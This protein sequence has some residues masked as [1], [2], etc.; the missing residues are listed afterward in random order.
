[1]SDQQV[2]DG[3][4][5]DV[6]IVR[7]SETMRRG[8][9]ELPWQPQGMVRWFSP[10]ELA[11][12]GMRAALSA[13]F[14]EYAD[15]REL[16]AALHDD[17][18]GAAEPY[19][20]SRRTDTEDG[21][22]IDY[23]AD[24]GDGF[25]ST[26]TVAWLLAQPTLP[27]SGGDATPVPRERSAAPRAEELKAGTR[28][29][30]GHVLVMGGDQVYP[31]ASREEYTNRMS[32]PYEAALPW[33]GEG[34][35]PHLF[36][37]PG[38]HDWYDGLTAFIRLFTQKR[39]IGGWG[40][41][42][43]RSYFALQLP[44][45]WW[46]LGIDV[47]LAADIDQPQMDYFCRVAE[48][49]QPGDR[50]ILCTAEPAWVHTRSE[51]R[52]FD[53]LAFFE[54]Q[55]LAPR[56][57]ELALTLTGDLHHYAR[58]SSPAAEGARQRHK[59]TA[60][61]GGAYLLGTQL[62]PADIELDAPVPTA[63][64]AAAAA[65]AGED[66]DH[67]RHRTETWTRGPLYP[68][69]GESLKLK[70]GA[71]KLFWKNPS[72]GFFLGAVYAL[73]AWFVQSASQVSA[74]FEV[75]RVG[76]P[77]GTQG[78]VPFD[79]VPTESIEPVGNFMDALA[80]LSLSAWQVTQLF[81]KIAMYSPSVVALTLL[82]IAG[83]IAFT[84][85]DVERSRLLV[86]RPK[87]RMAVRGIVG[88]LHGAAHVALI[89][90]L[91]WVFSAWVLAKAEETGNQ[92]VAL[93]GFIPAMVVVGGVLGSLLMSLFLL[94]FVNYNEAFSAQHLESHKNFVRLR[95][96]CS[97]DLTVYA[98]GV[99]APGT[100]RFHPD[101][102]PGEPYFDAAVP[103]QVRLVDGPLTIAGARSAPLAETPA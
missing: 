52:A 11:S 1:M 99:D 65:R 24:L 50:V 33:H 62:L 8:P 92:W 49:M 12:A 27:A 26:Y 66:T 67:R 75:P 40:T 72:F 30:R 37:I 56:G 47:Q 82:F 86:K 16:Q 87:L 9:A 51:P 46:L 5:F 102:D 57:A 21:F 98:Y 14:G 76:S 25:R 103:P 80:T 2:K 3:F 4:P 17:D 93:L 19:D 53:N 68:G 34:E 69:R 97:G 100:W 88:F 18:V 60:G 44:E 91:M 41:Q 79:L 101:A 39:W 29:R 64:A 63:E 70:L 81:L 95:I 85:P 83:M 45:R 42:Q 96:D 6:P 36:A 13:V 7:P 28:T 31:T 90:G 71:W 58:Y 84:A 77:E 10:R 73:F 43:S 59:I 61:G 38:N 35:A 55:V 94:P 48:R 20:Y 89:V 22:W 74:V 32:G 54:K 15:R 23:V 78:A